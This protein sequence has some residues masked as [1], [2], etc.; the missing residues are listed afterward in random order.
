MTIITHFAQLGLKTHCIYV[1]NR[2]SYI[3]E[4]R[5]SKNA[6]ARTLNFVCRVLNII[7]R[8]FTSPFIVCLLMHVLNDEKSS[9]ESS[10]SH[11]NIATFCRTFVLIYWKEKKKQNI[12]LT[13][14][15]WTKVERLYIMFVENLKRFSQMIWVE[16]RTCV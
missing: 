11:I 10:K 16:R 2:L 12:C 3:W 6:I 14:L 15:H 8:T 1:I 4:L 7:S 13:N 5:F 9:I